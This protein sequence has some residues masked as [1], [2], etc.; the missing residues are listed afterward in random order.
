MFGVVTV[1]KIGSDLAALMKVERR[2]ELLGEP[3]GR[4][5]RRARAMTKA[6]PAGEEV[7]GAEKKYI[8][9]ILHWQ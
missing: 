2:F 8:P 7:P 5:R 6:S 1:R 3:E 4:E 9:L